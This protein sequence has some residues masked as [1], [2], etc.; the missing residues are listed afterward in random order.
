M[1]EADALCSAQSKEKDTPE[2]NGWKSNGKWRC[3]HFFVGARLPNHR[4]IIKFNDL[5]TS[6]FRG[7]LI[8]EGWHRTA[9]SYLW[10]TGMNNI[11]SMIKSLQS[12]AYTAWVRVGPSLRRRPLP[13]FSAGELKNVLKQVHWSHDVLILAREN[14]AMRNGERANSATDACRGLRLTFWQQ[15]MNSS[16]VTT[17]SLFLSIFCWGTERRRGWKITASRPGRDIHGAGDTLAWKNTSTCWRGVSSL[18]AGY[19]HFPIMS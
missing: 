14:E 11:K 15:S 13:E 10:P 16:M 2:T 4:L 3:V 17:P 8:P 1:S 12:T 6:M 7:R 5:L 18:R 19:V 9:A